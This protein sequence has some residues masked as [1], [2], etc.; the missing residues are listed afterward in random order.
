M[1]AIFEQIT[2]RSANG[3]AVMAELAAV[4]DHAK[5]CAEISGIALGILEW[6]DRLRATD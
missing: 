1:R 2:A 6:D 3:P 4:L 5:G